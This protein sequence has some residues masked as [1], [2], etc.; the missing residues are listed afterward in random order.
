MTKERND[1]LVEIKK[2][3]LDLLALEVKVKALEEE[4]RSEQSALTNLG[5][6]SRAESL[7][8]QKELD[9]DRKELVRQQNN[10]HKAEQSLNKKRLKSH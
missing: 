6:L 4:Q 7:R 10:L 9:R 8:K 5:S 3:E 2:E 1:L